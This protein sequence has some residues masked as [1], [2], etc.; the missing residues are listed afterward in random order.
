MNIF[1][2][3]N[4]IKNTMM[5]EMSYE[6]FRRLQWWLED[7]RRECVKNERERLA[8]KMFSEMKSDYEIK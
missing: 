2:L 4:K 8:E 6:N 1:E 7:F 5:P 3:S